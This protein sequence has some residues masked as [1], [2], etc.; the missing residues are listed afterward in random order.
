[1]SYESNIA[2]LLPTKRD[3][4]LCATGLVD[5]LIDTQNEFLER[6]HSIKKLQ[7]SQASVSPSDLLP[8]HLIAYDLDRD[9]LPLI[10][11]QC[12]YIVRPMA[13]NKIEYNLQGL[14]LQLI[15]RFIR[16]RAL[17]DRKFDQL[18]FRQFVRNASIFKIL[19]DKIPQVKL[20]SAV[21]CSI[22]TELKSFQNLC[23]S[24][25]S[26]DIAIGFLANYKAEGDML[27]KNYLQDKLAMPVDKGLISS[28]A[29]Q[30]CRLKHILALWQVLA[31]DKALR[32]TIDAQDPFDDIGE[33]YR[34][35]LN[36]QQRKYL[37]DQL[38]HIKVDLLCAELFEYIVLNLS[39][40]STNTEDRTNWPIVETLESYYESKNENGEIAGLDQFPNTLLMSHAVDTWRTIAQFH[41]KQPVQG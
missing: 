34:E 20:T 12:Q 6:Y 13:E 24:L 14:E 25:A 26:L 15:E 38:K 23:K 32:L 31:V 16:G 21:K 11:S 29:S 30:Q 19:R 9:L 10:L 33:D 37:T 35:N 1:M 8:S 2:M 3:F 40:Q 28:T 36:G 5:F 39:Y 17:I 27:I 4:G 41:N 7:M 18:F 22:V